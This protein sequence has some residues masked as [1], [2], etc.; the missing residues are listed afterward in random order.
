MKIKKL[1]SEAYLT[2]IMTSSPAVSQVKKVLLRLKHNSSPVQL[3]A[4]QVFAAHINT[5]DSPNGSS[6]IPTDEAHQSV[7]FQSTQTAA[8]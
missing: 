6:N 2:A 3:S 5:F 4:A 1:L 8:R 7:P